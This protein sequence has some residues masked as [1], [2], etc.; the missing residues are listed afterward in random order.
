MP[1]LDNAQLIQLK[2]VM[3]QTLFFYEVTGAEVKLKENDRNDHIAM[4]IDVKR[5]EGCSE[6]SLKYYQTMIDV[7]DASLSKNFC[8]IHEVKRQ[9]T[10]KEH[11]LMRTW[12][13]YVITVRLGDD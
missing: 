12:R 5:I 8:R 9:A 2:Q 1:Y 7:M 10:S 3:K 11:T 13:R 4:L 6:K